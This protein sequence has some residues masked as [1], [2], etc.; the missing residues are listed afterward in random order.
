MGWEDPLEKGQ[1]THSSIL[2]WGIAWTAWSTGLQKSDTTERLSLTNQLHELPLWLASL[3]GSPF[4]TAVGG[5]MH[6]KRGMSKRRRRSRE[7]DAQEAVLPELA[8]LGG[9][10]GRCTWD[11][12]PLGCSSPA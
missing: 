8:A 11:S 9:Q 12:V 3:H 10:A 5:V 7:E 2:A 4:P 6:C 1:A